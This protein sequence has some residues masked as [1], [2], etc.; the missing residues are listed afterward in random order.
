MQK[1]PSEAQSR[2]VL[3]LTTAGISLISQH[4]E[5]KI[6]VAHG[7][8]KNSK[9]ALMYRIWPDGRILGV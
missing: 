9:S 8:P 7:Y 4:M 1:P 6:L 2:A 5:G 3:K